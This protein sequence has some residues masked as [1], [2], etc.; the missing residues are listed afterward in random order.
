MSPGIYSTVKHT[1]AAALQSIFSHVTVPHEIPAKVDH[2]DVDFLVSAPF[3]DLAT[4]TPATF[5]FGEVIDAVKQA[6]GTPH[7]Q[8]GFRTPT[9]MFFAVPFPSSACGRKLDDDDESSDE[10][11]C[12]AQ[13]DL[14]ICFDPSAF[15]WMSF[16]TH[17]ATQS[18]LL[19]SMVKPIGLTLD[20]DGLH[21]RVAELE[22]TDWG[23]SM[24]FVS[25]D[26]WTV[27]RLLGLSRRVVDG[28]FESANK[29]YTEYADSWLF[30]PG[31]F[32][33]KFDDESYLVQH[34]HRSDFLKKWI[35]ERFPNH[36]PDNEDDKDVQ[37]WTM[38]TRQTV[39]EKVFMRLPHTAVAYYTKL[40]AYTKEVEEHD[41][42][43]K[44]TAAIPSG[45]NGWDPTFKLPNIIVRE[46]VSAETAS[47]P[48]KEISLP[49]H[50]ELT[51]PPSPKLQ[52]L[53]SPF[54]TQEHE[55]PSNLLNTPLII[56]ALPRQPPHPCKASPPPQSM[57]SPAR[58]ACLARWTAFSATGTPHLLTHPHAKDFDLR[59]SEAVEAG[60]SEEE[61]L[62]W[63][64]D[65]WW[66]IWVRQC[67]VNWRGMWM[68]RIEKEDKKAEKEEKERADIELEKGR[69]EEA[70]P[71]RRTIIAE[72]L[73]KM[74]EARGLV[75]V[76]E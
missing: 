56:D 13:I 67:V 53:V 1:T 5:P 49:Q 11:G 48:P 2:G 36:E 35:P 64:R 29:I 74:N 54:N 55:L 45:S 4:M 38:H 70:A 16:E 24:V 23:K 65:M 50:D 27:A 22:N 17:Y 41:L 37:A 42:R 34:A 9:C 28:G 73:A 63:A 75:Q 26:P 72:R 51:P 30:H 14:K 32:K 25:R 76:R 10:Q 57:S 15:S 18:S 47:V 6:L 12:W 8:Q 61:L 40:A 46:P 19:G 69:A 68:K 33:A 60:C 20:H 59:W 39:K 43:D 31:H 62:V 7:G 66:V 3:G 58:L 71:I 44:I 52:P 21:L